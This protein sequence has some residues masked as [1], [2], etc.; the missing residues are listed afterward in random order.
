MVWEVKDMPAWRRVAGLFSR[1]AV[2]STLAAIAPPLSTATADNEVASLSVDPSTVEGR[3][4]SKAEPIIVAVRLKAGAQDL[5]DIRLSTFS[6]DGIA[7][8]PEGG[9]SSTDVA[10]LA[11][12]AE[13]VWRLKLVPG[14]GAVVVPAAVSVNVSVAFKESKEKPRQRYLFQTVKI[15]APGTPAVPTLADID[16]KGSLQALSHERPGQLFVTLTNKYVQELSVTGAEVSAPKFLKVEGSSA[17]IKIPYAETRVIAYDMK[18]AGQVVPGKYPVVVMVSVTAADGLSGSTA[19]T[20]EVE[21]AVLGESEFL[22]KLGAPSLLF[23]PGVLF[24]LS[25]QMLWSYGKTTEQ[26]QVYGMGPTAG[27]FWVVAVGLSIVTALAYP[28]IIPIVSGEKRDYL[29]A[30]G[31]VDYMYV[32]ALSIGA[33]CVLYVCWLAIQRGAA[34]YNAWQARRIT[35]SDTDM[36]IAIVEKLGRLG[37][38]IVLREA[39]AAGGAADGPRVLVL[40]A[41]RQSPSVWI[42]P[43]ATLQVADTAPAPALNAAQQIAA[44]NITNAG[45]LAPQLRQGEQNGWWTVGW[46]TVAGINGPRKVQEANWT[47]LQ[48]TARLIRVN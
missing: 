4:V 40:G 22:S 6:N 10:A 19:K 32:F 1:L 33:A 36:P 17:G 21:V 37:Q 38:T 31:L 14:Q 11:A 46:Q 24:L 34:R 27:A 28:W 13:Q 9:P 23:L 42:A 30:Y 26:R 18:P 7:A 47:E 45:Q 35:P 20:Q 41:W 48:G 12:N 44:G 5:S 8:V 15:T 2:C 39:H 25:W 16:I 3:I 43:P 29:L